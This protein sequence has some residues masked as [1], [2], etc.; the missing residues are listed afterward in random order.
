MC[1]RFST[2]WIHGELWFAVETYAGCLPGRGAWRASRLVMLPVKPRRVQSKTFRRI[3][4]F[5][6]SLILWGNTVEVWGVFRTSPTL[7]LVPTP[8][9]LPC[10]LFSALLIL[11]YVFRCLARIGWYRKSRRAYAYPY[12]LA[13]K[14]RSIH[15]CWFFAVQEAQKYTGTNTMGTSTILRPPQWIFGRK[16]H[17]LPPPILMKESTSTHENRQGTSLQP[18]TLHVVCTP[19]FTSK[20]K[21]SCTLATRSERFAALVG[22]Q[23]SI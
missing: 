3:T 15:T 13:L 22:E 14:L 21:K 18:W 16:P 7:G 20:S 4:P 2:G 1:P 11:L 8:A 12:F 6:R 23:T 19:F 9:V 5:D 17:S 10:F